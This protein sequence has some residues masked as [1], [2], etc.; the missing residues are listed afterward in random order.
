MTSI[1][2]TLHVSQLFGLQ[3]SEPW[4]IL[5]GFIFSVISQLLDA[6]LDDEGLLDVTSEMSSVW[7]VRSQKVDADLCNTYSERRLAN[8]GR[9][10]KM[11]TIM[12]ME[13]FAFFFQNR[14]TARILYLVQRNM[15]T[16]WETFV[17]QVQ[18]LGAKSLALRDS[19]LTSPQ[20]LLKLVYFSHSS[21]CLDCRT[22]TMGGFHAVLPYGSLASSAGL[23]HGASPACWLPLDL[24]LE[25][26]M[27]G[28]QVATSSAVEI[29]TGL[30]KSLRSINGT[31][32][33][34]TFLALWISALRLVQRGR[35]PIEGP[36]P[37]LDTRMCALLSITT[38]VVADLID[39]EE[40][41]LDVSECDFSNHWKG[42]QSPGKRRNDLVSCLK[43]LGDYGSLL[44]PP[45]SVVSAANLAAAKATIIVSHVDVGTEF[46]EFLNLKNMPKTFSGNMRHLIVEACIA[47]N[48]IDT[49]AYFWPGYVSG[50]I[51]K[52]S[53]IVS[54]EV[55]GWLSFMKG[56][57]LTSSMIKVMVATPASR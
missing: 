3:T 26:A 4:I 20:A 42:K 47:R 10:Q 8:L 46:F 29:I 14:V 49:S 48:L 6:S 55:P 51:D 56:S 41:P 34:D 7:A 53:E 13:I 23:C 31:S 2:H 22:S 37:C 17:Q 19:K 15:P 57:Q 38:L 28:S 25:D 50:R 35:D 24:V 54:P 1:E 43:I 32:W 11:N 9:L 40:N 39:E 30:V 33:H 5:V 12:A 45:Q 36:V 52:N 16:L 27:D 44:T 18:L 21:L